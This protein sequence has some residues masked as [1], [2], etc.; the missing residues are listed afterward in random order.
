R[1]LSRRSCNIELPPFTPRKFT[2]TEVAS[3]LRPGVGVIG[4]ITKCKKCPRWHVGAS[5]GFM[6]TAGGVCVTCYHVANI[7][8][9]AT[10]IAMAGD[11]RIVPVKEI[12][13][14]N[15]HTDVAL[16]RLPG[17]GF[18]APALEPGAPD[19]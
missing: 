3:V 19:G 5:S 8:G 10:L 7:P 12:L 9:S 2:A 15:P 18:S 11:G 13:A 4:D 6:L 14:A 16:L 17:P 1:Q